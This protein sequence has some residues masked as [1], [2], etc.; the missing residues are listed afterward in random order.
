LAI[1][2]LCAS[3]VFMP[4]IDVFMPVIIVLIFQI[5]KTLSRYYSLGLKSK[6]PAN[7]EFADVFA[8]EDRAVDLPAC[9]SVFRGLSEANPVM[10]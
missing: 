10:V 8:Q 7:Q 2:W 4:V 6:T 9:K 3:D 1:R 5:M